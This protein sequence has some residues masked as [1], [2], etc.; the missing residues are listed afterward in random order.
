M[1]RTGDEGNPQL[2]G[3]QRLLLDAMIVQLQ[4]MMRENNE[5]LYGIIEQI[6]NQMNNNGD[7]NNGD[8]RTQD[9]RRRRGHG[10]NIKRTELNESKYKFP[11]LKEKVI[12]R[13]IWSGK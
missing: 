13:P 1:T 5:E 10:K 7:D 8:R 9:R 2:E 6:E 3:A 4:R 12:P 11:H